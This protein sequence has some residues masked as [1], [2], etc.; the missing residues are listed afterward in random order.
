MLPKAPNIIFFLLSWY[1][2]RKLEGSIPAKT[3]EDPFSCGTISFFPYKFILW[4]LLNFVLTQS[5]VGFDV[6]GTNTHYRDNKTDR[7]VD[8]SVPTDIRKCRYP[9]ACA[10]L[11]RPHWTNVGVN[12]WQKS[13]II[14]FSE[15]PPYTLMLVNDSCPSS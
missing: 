15:L 13:S 9:V 5:Q 6:V 14:S 1:L 12:D 10:P 2:Y 8:F 3:L 11:I 7:V 4:T